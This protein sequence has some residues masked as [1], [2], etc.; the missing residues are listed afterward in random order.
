MAL[1]PAQCL[2]NSH[3][4]KSRTQMMLAQAAVQRNPLHK[5]LLLTGG[6]LHMNTARSAG[7]KQQVAPFARKYKRK[8][9][10]SAYVRGGFDTQKGHLVS[11]D[12][13]GEHVLSRLSELLQGGGTAYA[14]GLA[15][16]AGKH[17]RLEK[18]R[19]G[20]GR[21]IFRQLA[22]RQQVARRGIYSGFG[23]QHLAHMLIQKHASSFTGAGAAAIRQHPARR[24]LQKKAVPQWRTRPECRR[25]T[26]CDSSYNPQSSFIS[27]T[28]M[29]PLGNDFSVM[30]QTLHILSGLLQSVQCE[31]ILHGVFFSSRM[32][33][34]G[35]A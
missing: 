28:R 31:V 7:G 10:F 19:G 17:L 14:S 25:F 12:F 26:S 23:K 4:K 2:F 32:V 1:K 35:E 11:F 33:L 21:S 13:H 27:T 9:A 22:G 24:K 5:R 30:V 6:T 34:V 16:S 3:F 8:I 29:R 20:H 15:S 18:P